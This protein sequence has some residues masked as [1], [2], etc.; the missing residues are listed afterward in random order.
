MK[1]KF[2]NWIEEITKI[3]K[4]GANIIALYFGLFE[5]ENSYVLYL[6]GSEEYDEKDDDWAVNDDFRAENYLEF[7]KNDYNNW[8]IVLETS[9]NLVEEYFKTFDFN[10]SELK[11]IQNVSIGF[12]DGD[13]I[14][15][16]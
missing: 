10:N 6:S 1:E 5:S 4:L 11:N 7:S 3:E 14:K 9:K 13:L 2:K 16:I 8:E 15:I 12:D